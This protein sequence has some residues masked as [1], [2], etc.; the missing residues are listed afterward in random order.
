MKNEVNME[1]VATIEK[2]LRFVSGL[3]KQKGR[4]ILNHFPVTPPQFV[5]MQ[6]L[7]EEGSMTIGELSKKMYLA[8]STTTDLIARM[9]KNN[10]VK[11][12]RDERDRRVVRVHL[13]DE[14]IRIID[15]VIKKR[16]TYLQEILHGFSDE[17]IRTLQSNLRK[18]H[19]NMKLKKEQKK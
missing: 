16:Q 18:L 3:I 10:L 8:F 9:E 15:E 7:L 6:W 12:V 13:L 2:D 17:E 19:D 5:A 11:R 4:E 14:G 1:T